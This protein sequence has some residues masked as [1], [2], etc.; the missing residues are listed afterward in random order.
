MT[1]RTSPWP[2][3]PDAASLA[4][5]FEPPVAGPPVPKE[6]A[7]SGMS[8]CWRHTAC[9]LR[10]RWAS[11]RRKKERDIRKK[12]KSMAANT[13]IAIWAEVR[14]PWLGAPCVGP[15]IGVLVP[16]VG[17]GEMLVEEILDDV[18]VVGITV[19]DGD[20]VEVGAED[21][22]AFDEGTGEVEGLVEE[23]AEVEIEVVSELVAENKE[24]GDREGEEEAVIEVPGAVG[25][26]VKLGELGAPSLFV[27]PVDTI[28]VEVGV[29]GGT[30]VDGSPVV[31]AV[32]AVVSTGLDVTGVVGS[33][34][35][36]VKIVVVMN[37]VLSA[38]GATV[39][40]ANTVCEMVLVTSPDVNTVVVEPVAGVGLGV[41]A[42]FSFLRFR[43]SL[44]LDTASGRRVRKLLLSKNEVTVI[45][46][47]SICFVG[48]TRVKVSDTVLVATIRVLVPPVPKLQSDSHPLAVLHTYQSSAQR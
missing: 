48:S 17:T 18:D 24:E 34:E 20:S 33:V 11:Q 39:M 44:G 5:P 42:G 38:L 31:V 36:F 13:V 12:T 35:R 7:E 25:S 16:V 9:L 27:G 46:L 45:T 4:P 30:G 28:P 26:E 41:S 14:P 37:T 40:V 3:N 1:T 15:G 8:R 43:S 23:S 32:L 2:V 47:V 6:P 29:V 19:S 22:G 10:R 21:E